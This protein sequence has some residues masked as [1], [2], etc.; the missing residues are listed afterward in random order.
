MW[1][2][3]ANKLKEHMQ[4]RI[5][6]L[7]VC[8]TMCNRKLVMTLRDMSDELQHHAIVILTA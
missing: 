7:L 4:Q 3:V 2:F 1:T 8:G 5:V 6:L